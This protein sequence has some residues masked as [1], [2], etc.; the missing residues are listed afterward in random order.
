[1]LR[2]VLQPI[3]RNRSWIF[4]NTATLLLV[5]KRGEFD[6]TS[7]ANRTCF[8]GFLCKEEG[9]ILCFIVEGLCATPKSIT[10]QSLSSSISLMKIYVS[11]CSI[12]ILSDGGEIRKSPR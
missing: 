6:L 2:V 10:F 3:M 5:P 11:W 4:T 9:G 12:A 7:A 8:I 1:M